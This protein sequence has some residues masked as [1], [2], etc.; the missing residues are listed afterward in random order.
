MSAKGGASV[1]LDLGGRRLLV[2]GASSG[3]GRA[4]GSMA[5]AAGARV[6]FAARRKERLDEAVAQAGSGA[7]AVACDVRAAADCTRA[8]AQTVEAFGGL[9]ALVY[10]TG[11]SPLGMLTEASQESWR[12]VLETNLVGAS[13]LTAAAVSHLRE[14]QGRALYV[15]SYSVRECM[16]GLSLYRVSKVA[17]DALIEGWR[18]EHPDIDFTR[19]VLGNTEGTEF[20]QAW[21]LERT[22]EITKVWL[23]RGVFP[24]PTVMRI[25]AAAEAILSVLA[26]RGYVDD[27]AIMPRLRDLPAEV[28]AVD[29]AAFDEKAKGET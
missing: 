12:E 10:V 19:C 2:V 15:S 1:S 27:L 20:A 28:Q 13:L 17:L 14:S 21:G 9:D 7:I 5:A 29:A 16:P 22:I 4:V 3:V 25:E 6:A 8:V 18:M 11:M 24:A 26:V 23:E